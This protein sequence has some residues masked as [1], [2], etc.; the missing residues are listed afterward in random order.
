MPETSTT[1]YPPLTPYV[2]Y[3]DVAGAIGFIT[4]AFGFRERMRQQDQDG[5]IR[6]AEMQLGD[7]VIMMGCPPDYKSP[8]DLGGHVTV[9]LYMQVDDVE[10]HF[11]RAKAAG[12]EIQDA[13]A[14][15]EYGVRMYGALDPEGQQWW[16]AQPLQ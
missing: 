12:A 2:F 8:R 13:P 7:A 10:A 5:T 14:D 11:Q 9:G 15:Q 16:F 1:S 6:H 4:Q 3:R